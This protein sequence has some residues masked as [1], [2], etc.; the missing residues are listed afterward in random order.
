M[1]LQIPDICLNLNN[2]YN[3]KEQRLVIN[4]LLMII[5][6]KCKRSHIVN[7]KIPKL[8]VIHTHRRKEPLRRDYQTKMNKKYWREKKREKDMSEQNLLF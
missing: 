8:G 4:T 5:N 3:K 2:R 6:L 1:Q 7:L